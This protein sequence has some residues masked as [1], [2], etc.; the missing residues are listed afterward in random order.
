MSETLTD[1]SG[2]VS[3]QYRQVFNA[4]GQ[5]YQSITA[6]QGTD[7]PT[8]YR[9][10]NNGNLL[11]ETTPLNETTSYDYDA[12]NRV[13]QAQEM[14][15]NTPV[16][17]KYGYNAQGVNTTTQAANGATT[18]VTPNGFGQPE[19]EASP[20]R[21]AVTDTYDSAGNVKT[22]K[23]ARNI[24]LTYSYDA[25]NRL[26]QLTSPTAAESATYTYDV[27]STL[28]ACTNGKGRLCKV[29]DQSGITAFAYDAFGRVT[30]RVS[31]VAGI[32]YTLSFTYDST[33]HL[34][35]ISLPGGRYINYNRDSERRVTD[36]STL[37]NGSNTVVASS[38]K[39]R[40]DGQL[41][42]MTLGNGETT[43]YTYDTGGRRTLNTRSAGNPNESVES[44]RTAD[45]SLFNQRCSPVPIRHP[46][47]P[48]K[49]KYFRRTHPA[50]FHLR[51]EWQ[52][53]KQRHECLHLPC[54]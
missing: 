37:M 21:G 25:L 10:D 1:A 13:L 52:S 14:V 53:L 22:R 9:Y 30:K 34:A 42:S 39:Y 31:Q 29:V 35:T 46:A 12:L 28:T 15:D 11:S 6:V 3:T 18:T 43:S 2:V 4:L 19:T 32:T 27:N 33:G 24:T 54:Q 41:S 16:T 40:P 26:T 48:E 45:H 5:L 50:K 7:A 51:R 17:T 8:T 20:D 49:R 23:D 47:T 44:G 36:F 38:L